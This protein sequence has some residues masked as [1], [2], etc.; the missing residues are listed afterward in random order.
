MLNF[1]HHHQP[2]VYKLTVD[3]VGII[4]SLSRETR[5]L[6]TYDLIFKQNKA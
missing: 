1:N 4:L 5:R 2:E 6:R 3:T